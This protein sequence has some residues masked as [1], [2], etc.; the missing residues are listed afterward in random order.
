M[1]I[2]CGHCRLHDGVI[3]STVEGMYAVLDVA[4]E[5]AH[6]A[7][8]LAIQPHAPRADA[9][10]GTG[11]RTLAGADI[12]VPESYRPDKPVGALVMLHG[13]NGKP[14]G[15]LGWLAKAANR[16]GFIVIAPKSTAAS[17]DLIHGGFGPDVARLDAILAALFDEY[18]IDPDRL[19][20]G[21]FSDGASYALTLGIAN[22][23]LFRTILA[24]S[25]GF[26]NPPRRRG[27]PRI[28]VAHGTADPILPIA[29]TSR[30]IVPRLLRLKYDVEYVE[31]DGDHMVPRA[32][33]TRSIAWWLAAR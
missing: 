10:G 27:T 8:Q 6:A 25:P 30:R 22:G 24:F 9:A 4:I 11:A 18:A 28:F 12:Y 33:V 20:I 31:F 26:Q 19:A 5:A 1:R 17:W 15:P 14:K 23:T 32:M 2:G 13:A 3:A 7:A 21:G 29:R 16:S